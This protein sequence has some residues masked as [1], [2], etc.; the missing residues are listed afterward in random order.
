MKPQ[1]DAAPVVFLTLLVFIYINHT[2]LLLLQEQH[3]QNN[4]ASPL[5]ISSTRELT[6]VLMA[7]PTP[8][9]NISVT[10]ATGTVYS[11][12]IL[13]QVHLKNVGM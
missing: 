7:N 3:A 11:K 4:V 2:A 5:K 1:Q 6:N 12:M 8:E 10:V 13:L 9:K